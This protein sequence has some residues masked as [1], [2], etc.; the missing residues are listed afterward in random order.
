W[1][2]IVLS[3]IVPQILWAERA[4]I[5]L[6]ICALVS[7]SVLV[8]VWLDRFSVVVGGVQRDYLPSISGVYLP[9]WPEWALLG[10]T[11]GL[12]ALLVLL[13]VRALP[14]VSLFEARHAEH[15]DRS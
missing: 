5:S 3:V 8:G 6:A 11:L 12:F 15:E 10:G 4:R 2:A 1:A 9:T 13:F 14:V 7:V